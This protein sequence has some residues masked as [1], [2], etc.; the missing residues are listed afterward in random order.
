[1]IPTQ[2]LGRVAQRFRILGEETRLVI[3]QALMSQGEMSVG[4][5]VE[6]LNLGQAN[7][8]KHLRVLHEAGMVARR[9]QG[10]NVLYRID[11]PSITTICELACDRLKEQ[12]L[13]DAALVV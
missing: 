10:T 6:Q 3:L 12:L 13:N 2:L 11:D 1:M 7:V 8:S 5:L 9:A 4:E